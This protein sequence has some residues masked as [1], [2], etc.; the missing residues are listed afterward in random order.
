MKDLLRTLLLIVVG[1]AAAIAVYPFLHE[2]G[3]ALATL[4]TGSNV[5]DIQLCPLPSTLCKV[6]TGNLLQIIGIGFG[7]VVF[8]FVVTI[9]KPPKRFLTWYLWFVIKGICILSYAISL[10]AVVFYQ[11]ELEI[12]MD[13]LTRV[14]E[15]AP[16]YKLI[17][18]SVLVALILISVV[19]VVK[20]R[21]IKRC[22]QYFDM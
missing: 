4:I 21:P 11:T 10:W 19:Q 9:L 22:M 5:I 12:V 16:E 15:Y 1:L 7:G 13:D 3:H 14:M 20:S 8:P 2:A 17:Y 6:D 18:L